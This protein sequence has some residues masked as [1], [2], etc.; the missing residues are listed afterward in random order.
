MGIRRAQCGRNWREGLAT[1]ASADAQHTNTHEK[2]KIKTAA[3]PLRCVR[4]EKLSNP[5]D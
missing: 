2:T 3:P 1:N 4:R 5:P